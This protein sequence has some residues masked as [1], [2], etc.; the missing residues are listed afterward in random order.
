MDFFGALFLTVSLSAG[1]SPNYGRV[2]DQVV[3]AINQER[4]FNTV[5][6]ELSYGD[7]LFFIGIDQKT[8]ALKGTSFYFAPISSTYTVFTGIS[9]AGLE[10]GFSHF[11]THP[12][13][14]PALGGFVADMQFAGAD[15]FYV[16]YTA[17]FNL[18]NKSIDA[19]N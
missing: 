1:V 15:T 12:S 18:F 3:A 6:T 9:Y 19:R 5:A 17:K 7:R 10:V 16:K 8:E 4:Y 13:I 11:C 14:S 2:E